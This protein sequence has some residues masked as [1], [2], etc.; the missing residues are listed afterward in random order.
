MIL[1]SLFGECEF[2]LFAN[3]MY[4]L[5]GNADELKIKQLC[6]N[7]SKVRHGIAYSGWMCMIN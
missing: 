3:D 7:Y 5:H 1:I 2:W 4:H 6:E